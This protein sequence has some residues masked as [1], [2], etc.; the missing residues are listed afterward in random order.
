MSTESTITRPTTDIGRRALRHSLRRL[1]RHKALCWLLD[2]YRD[3]D[4]VTSELA[5]GVV[6]MWRSRGPCEIL[7]LRWLNSRLV[8]ENESVRRF[9]RIVVSEMSARRLA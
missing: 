2:V 3:G 4:D 5:I 7:A 1:E 9:A 6:R 8:D